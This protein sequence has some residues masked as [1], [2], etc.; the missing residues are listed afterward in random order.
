MTVGNGLAGVYSSEFGL[1]WRGCSDPQA[2]KTGSNQSCF[3]GSRK[4]LRK[5]DGPTLITG[6]APGR[7]W[8]FSG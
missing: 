3:Q 8:L 1:L 4:A 7:I 5:R 2:T 6:L